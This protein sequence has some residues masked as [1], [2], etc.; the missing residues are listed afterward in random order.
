VKMIERNGSM[1]VPS[2]TQFSHTYS[3]L[4]SIFD[5]DSKKALYRAIFHKIFWSFGIIQAIWGFPIKK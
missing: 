4:S 1:A 2:L 3:T 5:E